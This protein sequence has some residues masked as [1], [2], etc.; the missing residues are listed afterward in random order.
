M[1]RVSVATDD[2]NRASLDANWTN[3]NTGNAGNV[4]IDSST[5]VTGQFAAQPTDQLPTARWAGAGSFTADQ[6]AVAR[7]LN[8]AAFNG[9]TI[10]A[11]V[12][13]RAAG[14]A[15]TRSC[16]EAVV[17]FDGASTMTTELAKWVSGTRTILHSAAVAWA[18]ND[19]IELEAEGTTLRVLKNGAAL[20]GSFT[21]TDA[22]LTTGTPGIVVGQAA[23]ADDW[24][25]GNITAAGGDTTAPT[26]TGT[27]T[28]GATTTSSIAIT[29]PAGADNVAVTAYDVSSDGGTT[30][31]AS[32]GATATTTAHTF[33]G[34]T[35]STAYQ[36]RVRAKDAAGNVSTPPL[37]ATFT[38][39]APAGGATITSR[40]LV[41]NTGAAAT[42][43]WALWGPGE[44]FT[45]F[46]HHA[47][48]G[49]LLVKR[50]GL[51]TNAAAVLT[52]TDAAVSVAAAYRVDFQHEATGAWGM[53]ILPAV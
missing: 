32:N 50:T 1:P 12:T 48:T 28:Q 26:L 16:Y 31:V 9:S 18:N 41:R 15:G 20:G 33:S 30:Y 13:V 43:A 37:S 3:Q 21:Q 53:D 22:A 27:I 38:T 45:A 35:A 17:K 49:A 29:W 34:L 2:F 46:V 7:L 14:N 52:F 24:Q 5:R 23:F 25:G 36:I 4:L 47:T 10:R 19:L 51:L 40:P 44:A 42:D 6:Y 8:V 39:S 11:G